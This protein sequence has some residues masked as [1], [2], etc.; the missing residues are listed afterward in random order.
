ML[1]L[2]LHA[3]AVVGVCIEFDAVEVANEAD[4]VDVAVVVG[5][6]VVDAAAA[7]ATSRAETVDADRTVRIASDTERRRRR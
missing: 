3:D 5:A 7:A 4:V 1:S 2:D 6:A